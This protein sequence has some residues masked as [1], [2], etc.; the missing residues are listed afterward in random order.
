MA[1]IDKACGES[2]AIVE[3]E[4]KKLAS[5]GYRHPHIGRTTEI[6]IRDIYVLVSCALRGPVDKQ[7][8]LI[9]VPKAGGNIGIGL[10]RYTPRREPIPRGS[11]RRVPGRATID[12]CLT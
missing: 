6:V 10:L 4:V 9:S 11:I 12:I 7:P 1:G 2:T 3:G 8:G 5:L